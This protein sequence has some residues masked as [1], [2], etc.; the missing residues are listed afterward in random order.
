MYLRSGIFDK[1][2]QFKD[3][4]K[5][6]LAQLLSAHRQTWNKREILHNTNISSNNFT[7]LIFPKN[8]KLTILKF[9]TK[10]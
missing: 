9:Y 5:I 10:F 8:H 4:S 7:Q 6:L 3:I 2:S 1:Q